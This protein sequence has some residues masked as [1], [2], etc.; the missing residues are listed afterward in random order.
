MNLRNHFAT[1]SDYYS[2]KI[3]GEVNDV[4]V[5]VAIAK[6]DDIPW[7][8]HKNEDELFFIFEGSLVFEEEGKAPFTMEQG[9]LYIVK[10]G[11]NHRISAKEECKIMLIENK[12]TAH[13]GEVEAPITKTI[14]EQKLN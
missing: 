12:T 8:N 14:E 2:P 11:I 13:T 7:H 4:F 1:I 3:I 10:K 5:K 9:D 6:G